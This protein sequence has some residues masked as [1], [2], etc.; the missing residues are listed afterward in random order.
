VKTSYDVVVVGGGPAGST[1]GSLLKRYNPALDIAILERDRFPREHI[2]ESQLPIVCQ[3]LYEMGVWDKVEAAGFP[4]KIGSTY[5][6]GSTDELWHVN[7]IPTEFTEDA[8][9]GT[10]IGQR[11]RLA[12]QV[13]RSHYD[14]ILLD[15]AESLGCAV[16]QEAKAVR[17]DH[18]G[19]HIDGIEIEYGGETS[20]FEANHYVDAS[21]ASGL[22]HKAFEIGRDYPTHLRNVAFWDYWQ[23]AEWAETLG[24]S[25]TRVQVLSLGWGWIW[26]IPITATRTSIGLVL[27]AEYH[28]KSGKRPEQLYLEALDEEPRVKSLLAKAQRERKFQTTKDWNFVSDRLTGVNWFLVGDSCGFADPILAAGMSL[29]QVSARKAAYSILEINQGKVPA[30]WLKQ[31]FDTRHRRNIRH[32]I[33]FAEFWYSAN[34]RFTDLTDYCTEI[35]KSAGLDLSPEAAFQ[36]LG[37]GGFANDVIAED[38]TIAF[39]FLAAKNVVGRFTGEQ[40]DWRIAKNNCFRLNLSGCTAE[41]F[42]HYLNG[43]VFPAKSFRRGDKVLPLVGNNKLLVD[44]VEC[45]NDA[46]RLSQLIWAKLT[47]NPQEYPNPSIHLRFLYEGLEALIEDGWITATLVAGRPFLKV[48]RE[49]PV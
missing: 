24:K 3:I 20:R 49:M 17:L 35:A 33:R 2:G 12:F 13:E 42:A 6:W 14:K 18:T 19:D 27:P 7:F 48:S 43:R 28:K 4:I 44:S 26:F 36:W 15:H 32:H 39:G 37:T 1:L 29:A 5:R 41:P 23:N 21:G 16:F 11:A 45:E 25:G 9:P 8:R 31:E 34:G 38:K 30:E 22:F 40:A 46:E 10:F 47:S